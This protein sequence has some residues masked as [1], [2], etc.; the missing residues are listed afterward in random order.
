[1]KG[2]GTSW[3]AVAPIACVATWGLDGK[4]QAQMRIPT[5]ACLLLVVAIAAAAGRAEMAVENWGGEGHF[6]HPGAMKLAEDGKRISFALSALPASAKIYR[7]RLVCFR[8]APPVDA[9]EALISAEVHGPGSAKPL[10]LIGPWYDAFAVSASAIR[11]G[12][13]LAFTVAA[14]P[15]WVP[16]QTFLEIAYEARDAGGDLPSVGA[17]KAVHRSGQT[18]ITWREIESLVGDD[19]PTWG[20][21]KQ[22]LED[23]DAKRAVRYRIY[24][25][26]RPIT[27]GNLH[28][29]EWLAEVKPLSGYNVNGRSPDQAFTIMRRKMLED[30][31]YAKSV[32]RGHYSIPRSAYDEVPIDRFVIPSGNAGFEGG[33]PPAGTTP[34][35]LADGTGLY[36]HHPAQAGK[37]YYAVTVVVN[38]RENTAKPAAV[39]PIDEKPGLGEPVFQR[40]LDM[41]VLFDY[42]GRRLQYVQWTGGDLRTPERPVGDSAGPLSNLPNQYYNWSAFVPEALD[43]EPAGASQ[44]EAS[45][46]RA[47][48]PL[49][50]VLTGNDMFRRP[51]W[52]HRLDTILISPHDA[53]FRTFYYGYHDS[54]G[55]L[56]S[57]RQGKIRP[58]T[59]RRM[60][61][62]VHWAIRAFN[63]DPNLITCTGDR[64]YSSTAALHFGMRHPEVFSLVYTCKGMPN[65]AAIPVKVKMASWHR[66]ASNTLAAELQKVVGRKE[67]GLQTVV[68]GSADANVWEFFNLTAEVA[69]KPKLLRPMLSFGGRGQWDW[70][71]IAEF[72]KALAEAKQPVI[73]EGTWGAVDPPGVKNPGRGLP[74]LTV[75]RDR[76]IPVFTRCSSDYQ[77]GRNG[78]GGQTNYG[79]WWDDGS[80]I[81]EPGKFEILLTGNVVVDVTPRRMRNFRLE[82]GEKVDYK[83]VPMPSRP[84][85]TDT[86]QS[87]QAVADENGLVTIPQVKVRAKSRLTITRS[88]S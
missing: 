6:A 26:T 48:V 56:R 62:F 58:Y 33:I 71:P 83:V 74:G 23:L 29:A 80:I 63:I 66:R 76:P 39:G 78:D 42:P 46:G 3:K 60:L 41:K 67:W 40:E 68:D 2:P 36:V 65:P 54:A 14:F 87:G 69:S 15:G 25:H 21:L 16:E 32:S 24:R 22:L 10:E 64:G 45:G 88:A 1:M 84:R 86:P 85:R 59:W 9:E 44:G 72:L 50:L 52:P 35:P 12:Q 61:A 70:P 27:A 13:D 8:E 57:L 4:G 37:G 81:D 38:G 73:S 19:R 79:V 82:P 20:E 18:F 43:A 34:E 5:W 49:E 47:P 55:T 31:D 51:R 77:G 17:V 30:M 75:R 28:E 7:A 11:P 53:P